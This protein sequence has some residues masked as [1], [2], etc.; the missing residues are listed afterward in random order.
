MSAVNHWHPV[1][2]SAKLKAKP[3]A[4]PLHN[5]HIVLFRTPSGRIGA[6]NNVCKH[7]RMQLAL[8]TIE[9]DC[10]RCPYHAWLY[11]CDGNGE[12]PGMPVLKVKTDAYFTREYDGY[13]WISADE[14]A[15]LPPH[16]GDP[17][18]RIGAK[19]FRVA[20][21]VS[22][23][24][25]NFTEVEHTPTTH[26]L[27]GYDLAAMREVEVK[28]TIDHDRVAVFNKGR[29]KDLPYLIRLLFGLSKGDHFID[30]WYTAFSPLY[31]VFDHYWLDPTTEKRRRD[32]LR[33]YVY[34]VP[35]TAEITNLV[36]FT[37]LDSSFWPKLLQK[38]LVAPIVKALIKLEVGLDVRM[39]NQL[40]D[41]SPDLSGMT[42]GRFDKPLTAQRRYLERLYYGHIDGPM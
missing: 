23:V 8:G 4:I 40:A 15:P 25:D 24:M 17:F 14:R 2:P 3:V 26:A 37:Y 27:L 11:D 33:T 30:D 42:L 21:P 5:Q 10:L 22:I 32:R 6:L 7:R 38:T 36:T 18:V 31:S 1:L 34:F 41:K 19:A 9:G 12:S 29:Q 28:V 39:L 13:V 20:A 16:G 35:E